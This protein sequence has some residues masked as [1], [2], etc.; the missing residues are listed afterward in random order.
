MKKIPGFTLLELA[1]VLIV[2]GL[3]LG[4]YLKWKGPSEYSTPTGMQTSQ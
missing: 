1:I 3:F 4:A 2:L